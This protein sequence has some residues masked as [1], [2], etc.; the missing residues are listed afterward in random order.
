MERTRARYREMLLMCINYACRHITATAFF[1]HCRC[2][3]T[4]CDSNKNALFSQ[5]LRFVHKRIGCRKRLLPTQTHTRNQCVCFNLR[6]CNN[7]T[8][9]TVNGIVC[10]E[11]VEYIYDDWRPRWY[12]QK[13]NMK[14]KKSLLLSSPF[15]LESLFPLLLMLHNFC[16][17]A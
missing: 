13:C 4:R 5:T 11:C 8:A 9:A 1:G 12:F 7:N 10:D 17:W 3:V 6:P 14:I 2:G 15:I 16:L